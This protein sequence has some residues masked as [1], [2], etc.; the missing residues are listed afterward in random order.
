MKF[1]N[2]VRYW[3][4]RSRLERDLAEE[5]RLHRERLEEQFLRDGMAPGDARFAAARQFGPTTTAEEESRDEWSVRSIDDILKDLRFALRLMVRQPVLTAA[6]ALTVAFGVGANTAIVSVLQTVLLNPLGLRHA[7][8]VMAARVRLDTIRMRHAAVSGVE[9]RE[10][11]EM[12]DAFSAV[13]AMAGRLWTA[14][15]SGEPMRLR[16]QAVTSDFFRVFG[17]QPELGRFFAPED[18][19]FQTV[20]LSHAL[21]QSQFGSD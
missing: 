3:V 7:D 14:Q 21:W 11:R 18:Q 10:I 15:V 13:A 8:K 4:V 17:E 6:A 20:I 2:R 9:F 19:E 12:T 5:M 16:G 1:L